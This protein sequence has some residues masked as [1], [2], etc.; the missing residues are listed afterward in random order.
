MGNLFLSRAELLTS[1]SRRLGCTVGNSFLSRA[2]QLASTSRRLGGTVGNSFLSRAEQ[3]TS[4]SRRLGG[5]V[6]VRSCPLLFGC[7]AR[8]AVLWILPP[9]FGCV[10][11]R[12]QAKQAEVRV[13]LTI[14]V[15]FRTVLVLS[16]RRKSSG[17]PTTTHETLC[18]ISPGPL[19]PPVLTVSPAS[20]CIFSFV[21][22]SCHKSF[23]DGG[24]PLHRIRLA[25]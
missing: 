6:G 17:S 5:T 2:E 12:R 21:M 15:D 14:L 7:L 16:P 20:L 22:S 8:T 11:L 24:I 19:M 18:F 4:T 1:T 23:T 3:L 25:I 10:A 9:L 13:T